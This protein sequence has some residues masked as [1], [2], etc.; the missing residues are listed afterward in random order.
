MRL[1][2]RSL[3]L[4][5]LMLAAASG[6]AV[7]ASAPVAAE[8]AP[9]AVE[10]LLTQVIAAGSRLVAL[11]SRGHVLLSD[12]RGDAWQQVAM[13]VNVLL[14]AGFFLNSQ[15]GWIVGHDA[16]ILHTRDGGESWQVQQFLLG[17]EPLLDVYFNDADRGFA[18]GAYGQFLATSDGGTT[19]TAEENLLTEEGLHLNAVTRLGDGRL[20]LVGEQGMLAQSED[21]GETWTRLESPYETSLFSVVGHG[22]GGALV[23]GMRGIAFMTDSVG[24]EGWRTIETDSVQSIFGVSAA[25][26]GLYWLAGLNSSLLAVDSKGERVTVVVSP[27]ESNGEAAEFA[28]RRE[29][30]GAAFSDVL[31]LEDGRIIT[32]G[33]AG[34]RRWQS[35]GR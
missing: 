31:A 29:Q 20:L 27:L 9:R 32:V 35:A 23:G 25:A 15:V 30:E 24:A 7:K 19:W 28:L 34:V 12:D 14:T 22:A 3:L 8:M 2:P 17:E 5:G 26:D 1:C 18:I 16:T 13:P 6:G 4:A 10:D 33:D 11:G 21:G